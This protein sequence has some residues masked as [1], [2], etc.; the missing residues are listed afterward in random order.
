[1]LF[2]LPSLAPA[3]SLNEPH[4]HA[5]WCGLG[6]AHNT[7][8]NVAESPFLTVIVWTCDCAKL[9]TCGAPIKLFSLFNFEMI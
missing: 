3:S 5:T 2:N 6:S 9:S 7:S 4:S 1:M 8:D